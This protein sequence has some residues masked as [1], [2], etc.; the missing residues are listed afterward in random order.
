M[1]QL[2]RMFT[3]ALLAGAVACAVSLPLR[4]LHP[5]PMA[6]C[7]AAVFGVVYFTAA[8]ALGL[9]EAVAFSRMLMRR[10]GRRA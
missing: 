5:L 2:L 9:A 1:G 4:H 8:R 10:F 3:A 7:V 6:A